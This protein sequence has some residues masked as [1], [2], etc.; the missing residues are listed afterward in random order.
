MVTENKPILERSPEKRKRKK[1]R[2]PFQ[3]GGREKI[4]DLEL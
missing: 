1:N 2:D 4:Y 3:D